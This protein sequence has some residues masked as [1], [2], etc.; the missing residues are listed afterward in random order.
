MTLLWTFV[1][2]THVTAA[3]FWVGGQLMLS[4]VVLP[5]FRRLAPPPLVAQVTI[6]A[7]RRFARIANRGLLPVLVVSGPLLA[8][9]DGVRPSTIDAT[10]FG[11]VLEVK[12]VLV[13]VVVGL[14]LTHGV[15]AKR[16]SRRGSRRLGLVTMG[17]SVLIL[18]FAAALAV[19][20]SPN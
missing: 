10:V 4:F 13:L 11:Q 14:A 17:L 12:I 7:A 8:W 18:G 5:A 2:F 1:L 15:T 19:L 6:A 3:V 20:P 9:H 16:L